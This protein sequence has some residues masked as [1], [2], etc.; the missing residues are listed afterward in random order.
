MRRPIGIRWFTIGLIMLGALVNF[1][2]RQTLSI[3]APTVIASLHITTAQYG[4][5]EGLRAIPRMVIANFITIVAARRAFAGYLR[6][7]RGG[8]PAWDKTHHSSYPPA[9]A[10]QLR[11]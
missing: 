3:A 5:R 1:L 7:I 9:S 6:L 8:H 4:W 2:S 11:A 10:G